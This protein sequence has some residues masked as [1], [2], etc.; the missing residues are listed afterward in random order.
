[1]LE[2]DFVSDV[3]CPWCVI[4]LRAL[5][6]ALQR[7]GTPAL[8]RFQPFE[9]NPAMPAEGQEVLEHLRE[10]YG[11]SDEQIAVNQQRIRERGA[12]L[13]FAFGPRT[14]IW[15]TFAAHRLLHEAGLQ[16]PVLQRRLKHALLKRYHGEGLDPGSATTL[17]AAAQEAGLQDFERVID[18]DLHTQA[19]R[20]AQAFWH[21]AGIQAVPAVVFNRRFLV[22]GGQPVEVFEQALAQAVQAPS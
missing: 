12:E 18:S 10:K 21:Q 2:I 1:M 6:L 8:L 14:R 16:S 5:E 17:R 7:S 13:G 11:I 20:E 15:N 9:L 22:S 19:V 4:G 3:A